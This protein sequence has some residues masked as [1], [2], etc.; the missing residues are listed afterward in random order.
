[1]AIVRA[2]WCEV[3]SRLHR[4]VGPA[5]MPSAKAHGIDIVIFDVTNDEQVA[6]SYARAKE[7]GLEEFFEAHK[8]ET[9]TVGVWDRNGRLVWSARGDFDTSHYLQAFEKAAPV[10]SPSVQ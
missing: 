5:I 10:Q 2:D 3:C 6:R 8:G 1:M 4:D 7:L 9:S